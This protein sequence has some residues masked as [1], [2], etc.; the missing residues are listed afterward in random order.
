M[1][2]D[3]VIRDAASKSDIA[4]G[5]DLYEEVARELSDIGLNLAFFVFT[6][7]EHS[8]CARTVDGKT[9]PHPVL[10]VYLKYEADLQQTGI[11][12]HH[13]NWD[14]NWAQTRTVRDA[15]NAVLQRRRFGDAYVSYRTFIFVQTLEELVFREIGRECKNAV[16]QF[17]CDQAPGVVV[18]RIFWNGQQYDVIM[19]NKTDYK[20]VKH[21][22]D[23]KI[24]GAIPGILAS[25]DHDRHCRSYAAGIR[26]GHSGMSLFHLIREDL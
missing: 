18:S 8:S 17:I 20:R 15:L 4:L 16:Q 1:S 19:E 2:V 14:D 21:I 13:G 12:R 10:T 7:K 9:S 11:D 3:D 22:L 26:L 6:T 23:S 25:A 24:S 5:S